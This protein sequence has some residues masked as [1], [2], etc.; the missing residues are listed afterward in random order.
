[1]KASEMLDYKNWAVVG[2]VTNNMKYAYKILF[3]LK[4]SG[5]TV[6]GV[7]PRAKEDEICKSLSEVDYK[8]DVLDLCINPKVG[9]EIVKE[10][11]ELGIDKILIQPGAESEEI[12]NYCKENNITAVQGC[13]LV[14]LSNRK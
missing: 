11:K 3:A 2:S 1:M 14:E 9:I 4:N 6:K 12:L 8:I 7:N 10:A 13:A 5:Y